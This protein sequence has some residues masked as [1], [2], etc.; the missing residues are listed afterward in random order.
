ML[1]V[2]NSIIFWSATF[3]ALTGCSS[4]IPDDGRV[5]SEGGTPAKDDRIAYYEMQAKKG[6]SAPWADQYICL[7][8]V[9]TVIAEAETSFNTYYSSITGISYGLAYDAAQLQQDIE[10]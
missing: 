9:D 2:F 10:E 3:I 8:T 5:V 6:L 7:I 4:I 1:R